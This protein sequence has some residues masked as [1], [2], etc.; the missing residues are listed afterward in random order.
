MAEYKIY[1][2][3][4]RGKITSAPEY[5]EAASDHAAMALLRSRKLSVHCEVWSGNQLVGRVQPHQA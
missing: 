2:L 1:C 5:I 3:D 4:G